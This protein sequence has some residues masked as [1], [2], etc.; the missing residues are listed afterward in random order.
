MVHIGHR[1]ARTAHARARREL[2]G[3]S[4][5]PGTRSRRRCPGAL[6]AAGSTSGAQRPSPRAPRP[7]PRARAGAAPRERGGLRRARA[8]PASTRP[9]AIDSAAKPSAPAQRAQAGESAPGR[10]NFGVGVRNRRSRTFVRR[11]GARA[12]STAATRAAHDGGSSPDGARTRTCGRARAPHARPPPRSP[13]AAAGR[14][15]RRTRG[16]LARPPRPVDRAR[17]LGARERSAT[18]ATTRASGSQPAPAAARVARWAR[19]SPRAR[20]R[21]AVAR[22]PVVASGGDTSPASALRRWPRRPLPPVSRSPSRAPRRRRPGIRRAA[23]RTAPPPP[24]RPH[25]AHPGRTRDQRR[26]AP[27]T[28]LAPSSLLLP[29][30]TPPPHPYLPRPLGASFA[31]A[32][33]THAPRA[34]HFVRSSQSGFSFRLAVKDENHHLTN[35]AHSASI[36]LQFIFKV[37][38]FRFQV[39]TPCRLPLR[40]SRVRGVGPARAPRRG[41]V[42]R[43]DQVRPPPMRWR[44]RCARCAAGRRRRATA[45]RAKR[46]EAAGGGAPQRT[47][48]GVAAAHCGWIAGG[49]LGVLA[50]VGTR[51]ATRSLSLSRVRDCLCWKRDRAG[52]D[53]GGPRA[54]RQ[55]RRSCHPG[56]ALALAAA[57][58]GRV[59]G[60]GGARRGGR[61]GRRARVV[62]LPRVQ[63]RPGGRGGR[64]LLLRRLLTTSA[65]ACCTRRSRA[66]ARRSSGTSR[67]ARARARAPPPARARAARAPARRRARGW[68]GAR[69]PLPLAGPPHPPP[70]RHLRLPLLGE[71]GHLRRQGLLGV[72]APRRRYPPL[73]TGAREPPRAGSRRAASTRGPWRRTERTA[74][75]AVGWRLRRRDA[76]RPRGRGCVRRAGVPGLGGGR[77]QSLDRRVRIGSGARRRRRRRPG[78]CAVHQPAAQPGALHGLRGAVRG[79]GLGRHL[80]R[81]LLLGGRQRGARRDGGRRRVRREA[82]LLPPD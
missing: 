1:Y 74:A 78:E 50:V 14:R 55:R 37:L 42:P 69:G 15:G 47:R 43:A 8:L 27:R 71:R 72:Q 45:R 26:A 58:R 17:L 36:T 21:R 3:G 22:V 12:S 23:P 79:Q 10:E 5:A 59:V 54:P 31:G 52:A 67:C 9:A 64:L 33:T 16:S 75:A 11:A 62:R 28:P 57:A 61:R 56:L 13:A 68:P 6:H 41:G 65:S 19:G 73:A 81:E 7:L 53:A 80:R 34:A 40:P 18:S 77:Q 20:G 30:F 44:R 25:P 76:R 38:T 63:H 29:L 4:Y 66:R 39:S 35:M 2:M 46:A 49:L 51:R 48:A 32:A 82:R 60:G 70:G 24:P